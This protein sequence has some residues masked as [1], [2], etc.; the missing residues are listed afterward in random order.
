[1]LGEEIR[2]AR[3]AAGLTQEELA[4]RAGLAR[5]YISLLELNHKSPTVSTLIRICQVLDIKAS[6][7][8]ARTERSK[9]RGKH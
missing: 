4:F 3:T 8:L 2:N 5:N 6:V 1:V 7:L 9:I